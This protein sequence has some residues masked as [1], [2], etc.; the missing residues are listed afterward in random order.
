[1]KGRGF[2]KLVISTDIIR[3][4][5]LRALITLLLTYLLSPLPL[6]V[7][8]YFFDAHHV[9]SLTRTSDLGTPEALTAKLPDES[10]ATYD[11][12]YSSR[13]VSL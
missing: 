13:S 2:S 5:P 9:C 6:Q 7:S 3:V 10:M 11:F 1:M 8:L 4:T 12:S